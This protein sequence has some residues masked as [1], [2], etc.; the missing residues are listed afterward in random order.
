MIHNFRSFVRS[1]VS[2][3]RLQMYHLYDHQGP[4]I[5]RKSFMKSSLAYLLTLPQSFWSQLK[6]DP[7]P[8]KVLMSTSKRC[9]LHLGRNLRRLFDQKFLLMS[10]T[11]ISPLSD[12]FSITWT[13]CNTSLVVTR[14]WQVVLATCRRVVV[15]LA[16]DGWLT[17]LHGDTVCYRRVQPV[18]SRFPRLSTLITS[19][20]SLSTKSVRSH[21]I[22]DLV[23]KSSKLLV[24]L[25]NP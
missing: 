21:F 25:V 9:F 1:T 12:L 17:T 8:I 11:H 2:P 23:T 18:V 7:P 5:I 13:V 15:V 14:D 10:C 22:I 20:T 16:E 6:L 24:Y 4:C 19:P 3:S